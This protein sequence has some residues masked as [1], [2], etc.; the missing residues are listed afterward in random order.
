MSSI[1][2][3]S[4]DPSPIQVTTRVLLIGALSV[5]LFCSLRRRAK[6]VKE[7]INLDLTNWIFGIRKFVGKNDENIDSGILMG[8]S[9]AM[10]VMVVVGSSTRASHG[11]GLV[12]RWREWWAYGESRREGRG[13]RRERW[14]VGMRGEV[15]VYVG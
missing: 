15:E 14:V 10:V 4:D 13:V 8:P 7:L 2:A 3:T 5:F 12:M 1:F 11:S 6:R 9:S